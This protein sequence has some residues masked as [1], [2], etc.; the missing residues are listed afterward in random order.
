MKKIV[1]GLAIL[2]MLSA[3]VSCGRTSSENGG[4]SSK[5][6]ASITAVSTT[7]ASTVSQT[8]S[9]TANA[10]DNTQK[11]KTKAN[12]NASTAESLASSGASPINKSDYMLIVGTWY[13]E[14]ALDPRTLTIDADGSYELAYR[15]G[16]KE[17]GKTEIEIQD[18]DGTHS[19]T[20]YCF[21]KADGSKWEDLRLSWSDDMPPRLCSGFDPSALSF[22][23]SG[24]YSPAEE[25]TLPVTIEDPF[26]EYIGQ[27]ASETQWNGNNY[28]IQISRNRE[29][30]NAEVSAHSAV[31]DYIWNYSC[32]CSEDGTYIEC[33]D[34]GTLN[35]TDHAPNGDIQ[36]PVTV[37]SDGTARFD[38]K[39]G[40]LFWEDCKEGTARQVGFSKIG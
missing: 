39:G 35:R 36:E 25:N 8:A 16:G 13:E 5:I 15:G 34:G 28:Y 22:V 27:W 11:T 21:F 9:N 7:A 4:V 40:T 37:Y 26:E 20:W 23:M 2:T 33:T 17:Y 14:N 31:A 29:S 3:T 19:D 18:L 1:Y 30:I 12:E 10:K 38:I 24:D 6:T 32:V